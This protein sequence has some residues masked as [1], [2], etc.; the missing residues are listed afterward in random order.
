MK[1]DHNKSTLINVVFDDIEAD[2]VCWKL[3]YK[4]GDKVIIQQETIVGS[5][6]KKYFDNVLLTPENCYDFI[7]EYQTHH[8]PPDEK[9]ILDV[10]TFDEKIHLSISDEKPKNMYDKL[11]VT[12]KCKV[13]L[14]EQDVMVPVEYWSA[15]EY[16]KQWKEGLVRIRT[17]DVSCIILKLYDVYIEWLLLYK[18]GNEV[19]VYNNFFTAEDYEEVFENKIITTDNCYDFIPEQ[20]KIEERYRVE[21]WEIDLQDI[22][23]A[24]II[25]PE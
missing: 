17:H 23:D 21:E 8:Y 15:D 3:L 16:K 11:S 6:Y 18:N 4:R 10:Q 22:Y 5:L 2:H 19:M 24:Q 12:A 14:Y 13:D 9:W 25:L 20:K 1:Y 7:P